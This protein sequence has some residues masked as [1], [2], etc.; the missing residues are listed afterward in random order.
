M[1]HAI[2]PGKI[3]RTIDA[4]PIHAGA[5]RRL[6]GADDHARLLP[7]ALLGPWLPWTR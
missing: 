2:G 7:R 6:G 3:A 5:V 1:T 4:S